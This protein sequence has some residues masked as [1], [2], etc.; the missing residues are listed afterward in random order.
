[1]IMKHKNENT[2]A[3]DDLS[4]I[5]SE[6]DAQEKQVET[7]RP[8][9]ENTQND[10]KNVEKNPGEKSRSN[11]IQRTIT[12]IPIAIA[13]A[14][15][16]LL[17]IYVNKAFYDVFVLL[18]MFGAS[19]EFCKAIGNKF[20]KPMR[21]FVYAN[22]VAGYAVFKIINIFVERGSGG[23]TS[24]FGVLAVMFIACIAYNIFSK[25]YTISNVISTLLA[26]IYPGT[27][28]LYLLALG[29]LGDFSV[30]TFSGN[31]AVA[32]IMAFGV[33]SLVDSMAYIVGSTLKGPKLA[34]TVSPKKTISGA[35]GGL[36]GGVVGGIIIWL[37]A[38][39]GV[40]M[41]QPIV[42]DSVLNF[43]L[44]VILGFGT[45]LVCQIG[46]LVSSYIKRACGIKDFGTIL[47]GH[48]GFLDR[49][50]GVIVSAMFIFVFFSIVGLF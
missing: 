50:D 15:G 22:I 10:E 30:Q 16:I 21:G 41:T 19:Y 48:G 2:G 38:Q 34:P 46:D 23:I 42:N 24:A 43:V 7:A 14:A 35:V 4:L 9:S 1:M 39:N 33:T 40:V 49:I 45:A 5:K 29:Y 3:S 26:M 28:M 12:A 32:T 17:G 27:V 13:Y 25:K 47:K 8:E 20:A 11:F 31:A 36:V 18:L 37:F 6:E 44:F